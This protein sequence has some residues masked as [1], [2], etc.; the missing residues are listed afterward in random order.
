MKLPN[1]VKIKDFPWTVLPV[2]STY[3]A[4]TIYPNVYVPK[5][6]YEDLL[7]KNPNPKSV[8]VLIHE[9]THI[10]RQRQMGWFVWGLRY[11]FL[12]SFRF[13]EELVAIKESMKYMKERKIDWDTKRTAKFLSG[14]LYLWC[15]PYKKA[16]FEL[17]KAWKNK[18]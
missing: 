3:T 6:I 10:K 13:E 18:I 8:S 2:L 4:H 11:C 14:Y 15:V 16:K 9:Q 1:N 7:S 12:G 17:D 5:H